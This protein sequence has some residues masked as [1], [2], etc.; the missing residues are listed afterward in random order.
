MIT[1]KWRVGFSLDVVVVV[2]VDMV[3]SNKGAM[4]LTQLCFK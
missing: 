2:V 1:L 4:S 3:D